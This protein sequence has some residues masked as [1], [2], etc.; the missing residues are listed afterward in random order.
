MARILNQ[1]AGKIVKK[2]NDLTQ[3]T[4]GVLTGP[5]NKLWRARIL[6]NRATSLLPKDKADKGKLYI[7]NGVFGEAQVSSKQ[8]KINEQLQGQYRLILKHELTSLVKVEDGPDPAKGQSASEK[9]TAFFVNEVD[10]NPGDNQVI[11]YNLSKSPYQYIILQNRPSSLD[12][13]GESTLAT[14]KSMGRNTPMYHFTGS[15]DIIQFNI[16]W[17]CNDPENP[18]EVLFKCR[19]LESWTKSNGYQAGPPILMIQWGN[20]GI[21]INHKYILTSATYS[22]SNFRNAYRKRDSNGKPSQ[23][24]VSLGLTPSTATQELIFKRVSSYNLSYQDLVTDEDL[25]KT[26]GIQI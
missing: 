5:L 6:L 18:N 10:R 20:S 21:F 26:K 8:P 1:A 14:I 4:A 15:E 12:F 9:K 7:P 13:R 19:L 2:Y 25:K 24:I 22:L 17:F 16:S 11:I 23:E 3:D